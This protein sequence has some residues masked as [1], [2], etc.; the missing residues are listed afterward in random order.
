MT[1][2][3]SIG[4]TV[5]FELKKFY[6]YALMDPRRLDQPD[7]GI[8]YIGKGQNNRVGA[9]VKGAK[10]KKK[11][12]QIYEN[13]EDTGD[14]KNQSVDDNRESAKNLKI[15]EI[16]QKNLTVKEC[17]LGRFD[18]EAEAFAV[19]SMLIQWV[20]GRLEDKGQL[21]NIQ[22]GHNSEHVRKKS[23]L[24]LNEY[25]DVPKK[26]RSDSGEYSADKLQKLTANNIPEIAEKTVKELR[27]LIKS[28]KKLK[29][30]IKIEPPSIVESGRYVAAV[31]NFGES[32]VILRLQFTPKA[33]ITNLRA[34]DE[35]KVDSKRVFKARMSSV[36]LKA[37]G[38]S[39]Y[40][41]IPGWVNNGL[42]F[43]DYS[44]ALQRIELAF[45]KFR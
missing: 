6:V 35:N 27:N 17:I 41:W 45:D 1:E 34:R 25:L 18:T 19:E 33:L 24:G 22:P 14:V 29:D 9:H 21:T 30:H 10:S 31:V 44:S 5:V 38:G 8:F 40:G 32:D 11:V 16:L 4:S 15:Q 37:I 23:D 20:Y 39:K 36:N 26:M 2:V 28:N 43:D 12:Q 13:T 7:H 42:K 3:L